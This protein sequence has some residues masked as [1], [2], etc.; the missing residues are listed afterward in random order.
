MCAESFVLGNDA[1]FDCRKKCWETSTRGGNG[2][3]ISAG[4]RG[5][6]WIGNPLLAYQV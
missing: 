6:K 3:N 2:W 4:F 5:G 1:E